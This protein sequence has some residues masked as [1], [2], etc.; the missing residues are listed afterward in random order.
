[1]YHAGIVFHAGVGTDSPNTLPVIGFCAD[2]ITLASLADTSRANTSR[3][4][5]RSMYRKPAASGLSAAPSWEGY[6]STNAPTGSLASGANAAM[7]T[8]ALTFGFPDAAPVIT[9]PP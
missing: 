6:F 5:A 7:Y 1:M 2:D 8:S 4:F 9:A 3:N